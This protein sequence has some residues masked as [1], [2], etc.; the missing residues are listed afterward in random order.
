[1]GRQ[2]DLAR[3]VAVKL[4]G[5]HYDLHAPVL[6]ERPEVRNVFLTEPTVRDGIRRARSVQIA[7][8]GIGMVTPVGNSAPATW[9]ALQAGRS[10]AAPRPAHRRDPARHSRPQRRR[11]RPPARRR[12]RRRSGLGDD[13]APTDPPAA[14]L[15]GE[16][17]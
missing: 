6:V 15:Q 2:P 7:I 4:G 9:A 14:I 17:Q 8:T 5:R 1:V 10:G 11:S 13:S 3:I 12:H 16:I